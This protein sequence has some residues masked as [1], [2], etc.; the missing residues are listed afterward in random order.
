MSPDFDRYQSTY[1]ARVDQSIAFAR[2]DAAFFAELKATDLLSI[3]NRHFGESKTLKALDFGCGTGELD[4]LVAPTFAA[5]VGIDVS[6]GMLDVA[7][8]ESPALEYRRYDGATIPYEDASFDLAFAV[9]VFHHIER[10]RRRAAADELA[11][12]VRPGGLVVVYEHNPLNPLTRI[13]VSRCEFDEGVELLSRAET[14]SLL[15]RGGLEPVESRYIAFFPWRGRAL[16]AIEPRL[17]RLP[18]GGQYVVVAKARKP[19]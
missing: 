13:A 7:S 1:I 9:C 3:S 6:Q 4:R 11:R 2:T 15:G 18:L 5:V 19:S 14:S 16:R 12:V 8:R 17:A 10:G